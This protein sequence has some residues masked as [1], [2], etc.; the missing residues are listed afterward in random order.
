M[1]AAKVDRIR[2]EK[3]PINSFTE[4]GLR[5][6]IPRTAFPNVSERAESVADGSDE[7]CWFEILEL[8]MIDNRRTGMSPLI[9]GDIDLITLVWTAG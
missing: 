7:G 5:Q 6:W 4:K 9:Q 1:R 2:R 3:T 8:M